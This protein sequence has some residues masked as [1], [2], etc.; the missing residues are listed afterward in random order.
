MESVTIPILHGETVQARYVFHTSV[1]VPS[2]VT[3]VALGEMENQF[4]AHLCRLLSGTATEH[5]GRDRAFAEPQSETSFDFIVHTK[6]VRTDDQWM[7]A[8]GHERRQFPSPA[9][10]HPIKDADIG[11]ATVQL[12]SRVELASE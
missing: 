4:R 5:P 8:D 3:E 10:A 2:D 7:P 11:A 9:V 1:L 6:G 12:T